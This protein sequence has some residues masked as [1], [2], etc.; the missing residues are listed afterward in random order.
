MTRDEFSERDREPDK[1]I[2]DPEGASAR[3]IFMAR[4]WRLAAA[5][6]GP[7]A[8]FAHRLAYRLFRTGSGDIKH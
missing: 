8:S 3:E 5:P 2:R 1:H 7:G 4:L 6:P